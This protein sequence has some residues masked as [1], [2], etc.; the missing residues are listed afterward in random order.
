[1][2]IASRFIMTTMLVFL[3]F[4]VA[5]NNL[6]KNNSMLPAAKPGQIVV[7][8]HWPCVD[9]ETAMAAL[10]DMIVYEREASPYAYSATPAI[11]QDGALASI[12]VHPSADSFKK[13]AAW[14]DSDE[15]WQAQLAVMAK[16]CGTSDDL[17][18]KVLTA[19]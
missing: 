18:M 17:S 4:V 12:D 2:D 16:A 6:E 11:H 13:A 1:M 8:Y 3:T 7:I 10:K 14:Q 9:M 19:D 5:A 15:T